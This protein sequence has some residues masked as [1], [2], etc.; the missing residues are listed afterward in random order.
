MAI[1]QCGCAVLWCLSKTEEQKNSM[2]IGA[3]FLPGLRLGLGFQELN[4]ANYWE[5][6]LGSCSLKNLITKRL[7]EEI[8]N[9]Y[10]DKG[11]NI[12]WN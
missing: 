4:F 8:L 5:Y 3:S 2:A 6:V 9:I 1:G 11:K 12:D 10:F 7:S